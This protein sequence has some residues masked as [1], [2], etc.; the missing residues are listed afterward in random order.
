MSTPPLIMRTYPRKVRF[1]W[2]LPN[3]LAIL[4]R[5]NYFLNKGVEGED[6]Q[7]EPEEKELKEVS[8]EELKEELKGVEQE[9][10][11]RELE[12]T[13]TQLQVEYLYAMASFY[14]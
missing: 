3:H 7:E 13:E 5:L 12:A 9:M 14:F 11:A 6:C 1:Y 4:S 8:R 10:I 2:S